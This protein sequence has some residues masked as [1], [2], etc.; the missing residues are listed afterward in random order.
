MCKISAL[1][2]YK[3]SVVLEEVSQWPFQI[4]SYLIVRIKTDIPWFTQTKYGW[5]NVG[6][7]E[8]RNH[9]GNGWVEKTWIKVCYACY[10]KR[11]VKR[12]E[13]K[14]RTWLDKG[15]NSSSLQGA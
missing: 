15:S 10:Q 11:T 3:I 8:W 4:K 12:F 6:I 5:W 9:Q 7:N 13:L 1:E 14:A 2:S